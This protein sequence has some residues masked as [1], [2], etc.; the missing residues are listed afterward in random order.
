MT[1]NL[2][3]YVEDYDSIVSQVIPYSRR[4]ATKKPSTLA[5]HHEGSSDSGYEASQ[6]SSSLSPIQSR[7]ASPVKEDS[8]QQAQPNSV[9]AGS[10]ESSPAVHRHQT[11]DSSVDDPNC[12]CS[13][14]K[15]NKP[16]VL[17]TP[18]NLN[19]APFTTAAHY[20]PPYGPNYS[21]VSPMRSYDYGHG[22]IYPATPASAEPGDAYTD[23]RRPRD[24]PIPARPLSY[25]GANP[26][27]TSSSWSTYGYYGGHAQP[28]SGQAAISAQPYSAPYPPPINTAIPPS[29]VA[30][31]PYSAMAGGYN[32]Y[33]YASPQDYWSSTPVTAAAPGSSASAE[34]YSVPP[35]HIPTR[36]ATNRLAS[37]FTSGSPRNSP[38]DYEK[39]ARKYA[40]ES[41]ETKYSE[42]YSR[43]YGD[44]YSSRKYPD[45]YA[46][47]HADKY[48]DYQREAPVSRRT[49]QRT[50]QG[51]GHMHICGKTIFHH[52]EARLSLHR[53]LRPLLH[54]KLSEELQHLG[55]THLDLGGIAQVQL[56]RRVF[57]IEPPPPDVSR[58]R[59]IGAPSGGGGGELMYSGRAVS[60]DYAADGENES[61][62]M[63]YP[64]GMPGNYSSS[65]SS[66]PSRQVPP[67]HAGGMSVDEDKNVENFAN[68]YRFMPHPEYAPRRKSDW[69]EQLA[70]WTNVPK[71]GQGGRTLGDPSGRGTI[72][73]R[74]SQYYGKRTS[75]IVGTSSREPDKRDQIMNVVLSNS[76]QNY[77][78]IPLTKSRTISRLGWL[79]VD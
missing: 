39:W 13:K 31:G 66:P 38:G 46:D 20:T 57:Y 74:G 29:T 75:G 10:R 27:T 53:R 56:A 54:Q 77:C 7:P 24:R 69:G 70:A 28:S 2:Q 4:P 5:T 73:R 51:S 16:S 49:S 17:S 43:E 36:R 3:A 8:S 40:E 68:H 59:P 12:D 47:K 23:H 63:R 15:S 67:P 18:W 61:Y 65:S 72:K 44:K 33:S 55:L 34:Y 6:H 21:N 30:A 9:K 64:T 52:P 41:A 25:G 37:G 71:G 14:C 42:R 26:V 60:D 48:A 76:F 11:A 50:S 19:Y 35:P 78:H 1:T 22:H 32:S 58:I 62:T 45:D 79:D